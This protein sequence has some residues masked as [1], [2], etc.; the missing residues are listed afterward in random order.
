M[1]KSRRL[2]KGLELKIMTAFLRIF[3]GNPNYWSWV[4]LKNL[5]D[6]LFLVLSIEWL[7]RITFSLGSIVK[8]W[9][10]VKG[11]IA[12]IYVVIRSGCQRIGEYLCQ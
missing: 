4:Y 10:Y 8:K 1:G 9:L 12:T 6:S 11:K 7:I 3:Q 5:I 2:F